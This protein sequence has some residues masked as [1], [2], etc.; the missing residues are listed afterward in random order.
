MLSDHESLSRR[1]A[2]SDARATVGGEVRRELL[3][4]ERHGRRY[5]RFSV[6]GPAGATRC[7]WFLSQSSRPDSLRHGGRYVVQGEPHWFGDERVLIVRSFWEMAARVR[8]VS[9]AQPPRPAANERTKGCPAAR[10][11]S[12]RADALRAARRWLRRRLPR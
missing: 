2:A 11:G 10:A 6:V 5:L 9:S 1:D 8:S 4:S 3:R 7:Y 12:A